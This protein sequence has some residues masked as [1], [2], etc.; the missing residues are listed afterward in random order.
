MI[1]SLFIRHFKIFRGDN[2]IP[3]STGSGFSSIIGGNG[4]GKSTIL[5]ALDIAFDKRYSQDWPINN[6]A[7]AEGFDDVN[8]PYIAPVVAIRKD[9]LRRETKEE[10]ALYK[11]AKKLSDFLWNAEDEEEEGSFG[12][13]NQFK[14]ELKNRFDQE[15]YFLILIGKKYNK[16]E[17]YFGP[18]HHSLDFIGG[19]ADKDY[20][21]EALQDYFDDFY[22]YIISHYSYIYIPVETDVNTYT[23]LETQDMQKLMDRNIQN[24]IVNAIK[25]STLKQI[26]NDLDEFIQ[27]IESVLETYE[28]KGH[29]KNSL[30]MPDL[31]SKIIEAYFS[32]KV[33]NKITDG[34]SGRIP[35]NELSSGEKRKA[36]ID[37]A[38]SFLVKNTD[39][40]SNLIL[41]I[42][43]PEASLHISNAF[44][45]FEKLIGISKQNHQIIITTHWYGY[46]PIVTHG[47]ATSI[48]EEPDG[49]LTTSFFDLYNYREAITNA[50]A[51]VKGPLPVDYNIKSYNDLVQSIVFTLLRDDPYHWIVCEGISEKI[52]FEY[53]FRDE[54]KTKNLR[55]LPVGGYREVKK[56]YDYLKFPI[57]D[58]DYAIKGKVYCLIDTDQERV[59]VEYA[60]NKKL[61]FERL[62]NVE[63]SGTELVDINSNQTSPPT[64]IEDCLDAAIFY[65]TL[66]EFTT[67]DET[68]ATILGEYPLLDTALNS[69][70]F[71][72]LRRTDRQAIK[73]FFD[74]NAGSNKVHFAKKYV[75]IA[76]RPFFSAKQEPGWITD[77]KNKL[78]GEAEQK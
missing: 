24:V 55:I 34:G 9:S 13:F 23:K 31:V 68:L 17:I 58:P 69:F 72:D 76:E 63:G 61:F 25:P 2:F 26:N 8:F 70:D 27:D 38:Y 42:D 29:Y 43:E 12:A 40:D 32:I 54:I 67:E 7:K 45:Q 52:Y 65:Q 73:D 60:K 49:R 18:L 36:L 53:Y 44:E 4:V 11:K 75:E 33:L 64:E 47:S 56:I 37:I 57:Q 50:R 5:E 35:V 19:K 39:R 22:D 10:S 28:Y 51:R 20:K 48:K 3:L 77:I 74:A 16:N 78:Y 71:L 46:L 41:A 14:Q 21:E 1:V 15:E 66:A 6:E 30:T 59:E 62:L